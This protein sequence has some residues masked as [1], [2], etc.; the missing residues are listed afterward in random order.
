M[1]LLELVGCPECKANLTPTNPIL[2]RS[3]RVKSA[4]LLCEQCDRIA[5]EVR[6]FRCDFLHFNRHLVAERARY[7]RGT[8]ILTGDVREVD[9]G[10]D[11]RRLVTTGNWVDWDQKYRMT[12]G[13]NGESIALHGA[14]TD[15]GARLLKHPWSGKVLFRIDGRDVGQVDLYQPEL[16]TVEWFEIATD[17]P[18]GHHV[19]EIIAM[20]TRHPNSQGTQVFLER[21]VATCL[22]VSAED[23]RIRRPTDMT[24]VLPYW[25]ES[26]ALWDDVPTNGAILDCGGGDRTIADDRYVN[27]EFVPYQYPNVYGDT[28]KLPLKSDSF[29]LVISQAVLEHVR[30]PFVAVDEIWRVTKPGGV[31]WAGMAFLQPVH[32]VPSHYFNATAWGIEELFRKFRI[33]HIGWSG[34]L[35]FTMEWLMKTAGI[36]QKLPTAD[37]QELLAKMQSL[38]KLISVEELKGVA[39]GVNVLAVKT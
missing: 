30:N 36:P 14:F 32:A 27:V 5:G 25:D 7:S 34:G 3:G 16:S 39:S 33:D 20:G 19:V 28:L 23:S 22:D 15:L 29:D 37:Y 26:I 17:L 38:D 1:D 2:T 21:M 35:S 10:Y 12:E 18:I 8:T 11:D 31:V 13:N 24:R 6:N 9:I 4:V